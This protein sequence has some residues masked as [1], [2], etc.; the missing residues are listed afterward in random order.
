[1]VR[2]RQDCP[3]C[4][5]INST[6]DET[7]HVQFLF[8]LVYSV[9]TYKDFVVFFFCNLK[10]SLVKTDHKRKSTVHCETARY[11][12]ARSSN[13]GNTSLKELLTLC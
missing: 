6:N 2:F 9:Q 11:T 13:T 7:V 1:M 5:K 12:L 4:R 10:C 8:L 3:V